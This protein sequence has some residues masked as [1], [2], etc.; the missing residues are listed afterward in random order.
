MELREVFPAVETAEK[1]VKLDPKWAEAWQTLGRAQIG[2]GE[3]NMV[4]MF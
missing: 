2:L 3:I 1:A 4:K